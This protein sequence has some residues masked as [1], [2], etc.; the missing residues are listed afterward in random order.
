MLG[1]ERQRTLDGEIATKLQPTL[2]N[3][4]IIFVY[5][6]SK[7]KTSVMMILMFGMGMCTGICTF[8]VLASLMFTSYICFVVFV[9]S[10]LL[11]HQ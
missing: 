7:A 10:P 11:L 5:T 4:V 1:Q 2:Q 9:F 3:V 6:E 8:Y